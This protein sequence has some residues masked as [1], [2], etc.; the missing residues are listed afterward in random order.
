M[1]PFVFACWLCLPAVF[2]PAG[3]LE[4]VLAVHYDAK[5][6]LEK[7][8][9][10]H[11]MKVEGSIYSKSNETPFTLWVKDGK[12]RLEL[13]INKNRIIKIFDGVRGWQINPLLDS[14]GFQPLTPS[15][16]L[17]LRSYTDIAG[18]LVDWRDKGHRI[19]EHGPTEVDG[20]AFYRITLETSYGTFFT[21]FLDR[22][23]HLDRLVVKGREMA[24]HASHNYVTS[25]ETVDGVVFKKAMA[26]GQ[27]SCTH[28]YHV[29]KSACVPYRKVVFR[30]RAINV[31]IDDEL[32]SLSH[33]G[34]A[35]MND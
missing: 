2:S 15:E 17:H 3:D 19:V 9:A 7:L 32:F 29:C 13:S 10:L 11:T 23:T 22:E 25:F 26:A 35:G 5:G 14:S 27:E 18:L 16:T 28:T 6:G 31:D 1:K 20:K 8:R 33:L 12:C 34:V 4:Q 24:E 30:N 21:F